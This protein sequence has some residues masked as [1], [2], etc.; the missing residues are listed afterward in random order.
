MEWRQDRSS[1]GGGYLSTDVF[2]D[3]AEETWHANLNVV[4]A[5]APLFERIL[6][7][8]IVWHKGRATGEVH[9]CMSKGDSFP[10]IHGQLDV[11]GLAFQILDAPS[12]FSDIVAK[13]SFRG[14]RVFLHNAS[15]WFGDAPVEAS[16]DLGLNPE[17]GE[18]HLM[19]Q[20]PSVEVNA[21]M[22]TMK[23]KPLMFPLAGS[24]TAVFNCQG[25]LDAP[26]FVGS[27]IVSRKSFSV[28]GMPPSAASEAV[29]Q[30]KEAGAVAAFDHIP[31]SHVS[32]NFTFNLDNSVADLYGIR[33]CL[34]DG[35]EIR[36]AGNAWICPEGEGDDSAMDINLSGTILLDKVL[37]RY[38]PG[39]IQL[40][41]LKIGELNGETRLSG[42]LI[43][44][45]FDIKWA[46]P[47]AEDSFSDARGN[48]VIAHDYIMV[49][50]S[51]VSFDLNTRVQTS[52]IDDYL[53]NKETY[54]MKKIMPLIVEGVDLDLRMRG[55]EF[56]HIASSI[57]FDSP[58]PLHLKASGRVKFQGKIMKSSNIAD[59]NINGVLQSNID[60]NK[61]ETNVSKLVGDISL[62]GIKLNQLM[63]APQSTGFLSISRDSM[64]VISYQ[65]VCFLWSSPISSFF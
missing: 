36:G 6:E 10:S 61:L 19:C 15:G 13:L 7:I 1:Q 56:A 44:P 18:F 12:S 5:F 38:I 2:V 63:L 17:D 28:S 41:P 26:V 27:G 9:I 48:I 11:K 37:H 42:S 55:F 43:R 65:I 52:Y 62:S 60:Q 20:V 59:G 64:M 25:P 32:A 23:M 33:A 53:L 29:M 8:P 40:I 4:D 39:G 14:Q 46:A 57:P 16:G 50:S 58:R 3:I 21:L 24:V 51:S 31:F 54:Q 30:N 49:N 22:R 45:K 35:G 47:N 34:L